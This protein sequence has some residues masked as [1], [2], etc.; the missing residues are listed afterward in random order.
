MVMQVPQ[1][2]PPAAAT[3]VKPR[4]VVGYD[5]S[6]GALRALIWAI[7]EARACSGALDVVV[8][9]ASPQIAAHR[10]VTGLRVRAVAADALRAVR[11]VAPTVEVTVAHEV[12]GAGPA[13][14]RRASGAQVVVLGTRGQVDRR[15]AR[16]GTV[17]RYVME[18]CDVP[19]VLV[20][21]R[22][23]ATTEARAVVLASSDR[24][25][26]EVLRLVA[27]RTGS[28]VPVHLLDVTA[29][30]RDITGGDPDTLARARR[31]TLQSHADAVAQAERALG[32][33]TVTHE[34]AAE[35]ARA[36]L[37]R[38]LLPTDLLFVSNED[39]EGLPE[40]ASAPCPVIVVPRGARRALTV[41][42][43]PAAPASQAIVL[44]DVEGVLS[45]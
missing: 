6:T 27:D 10:Q 23:V 43:Q 11:R 29:T 28:R 1:P 2:A 15:G 44:P 34:L 12:G 31:L 37:R 35:P 25:L 13:I 22:A 5:G 41:P 16:G 9:S 40:L 36:V 30:G 19:V 18:H 32:G 33:V 3:L 20:G 8:S 26:S 42:R 45:R 39:A 7:R 38:V 17:S 4:L 24:P 21:P 14:C